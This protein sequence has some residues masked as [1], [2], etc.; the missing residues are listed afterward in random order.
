MFKMAAKITSIHSLIGW[1]EKSRLKSANGS[2]VT[3]QPII[4][5]ILLLFL[6]GIMKF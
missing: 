2:D 6:D 4:N 1:N 5:V 3:K